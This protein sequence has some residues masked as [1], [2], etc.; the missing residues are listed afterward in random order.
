MNS[1]FELL[2]ENE[3]EKLPKWKVMLYLQENGQTSVYKI[4]KDLGWT[5][6]KAHSAVNSLIKANA[7]KA[8]TVVQNNRVVKLVKLAG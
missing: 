1:K 3:L 7:V 6:G 8:S 5:A 4:A 2:L